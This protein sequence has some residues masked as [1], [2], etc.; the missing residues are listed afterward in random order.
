MQSRKIYLHP[1]TAKKLLKEKKEAEQ[2]GEYRI[3]KRIHAVLL[4]SDGNTSGGISNILKAPRSKVSEWL[5]NYEEFGFDALLEGQR[6]GRAAQL[7]EKNKNELADIIDS[8]PVAYGY[9][10]GIWTAPMLNQIINDEF[11]IQFSTRHVRRILDEMGFSIQ[12]PRRKL[13]KADPLKQKR[14]NRYTYPNLKKKR[15]LKKPP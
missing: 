1:Q 12:R 4:N 2:D 11:D 5:R 8:G 9:L 13:A 3:A 10:S 7:S 6:S 14:W 15:L